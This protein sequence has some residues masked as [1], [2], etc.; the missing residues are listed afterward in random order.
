MYKR[1]FITLALV[2]MLAALTAQTIAQ[3]PLSLIAQALAP[4]VVIIATPLITRLF[5]KLGIDI[6]EST[7]EPI[8]MRIIEIIASVEQN[9]KNL[10]GAQKKELVTDMA[11]SMLPK[12]DQKALV[13]KFGSL[14]TAVQAAFERSSVAVK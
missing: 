10:S 6:A 3:N 12:A 8:L 4:L 9:K 14:E 7:L 5:K 1:I 13:K 2:L 11:R